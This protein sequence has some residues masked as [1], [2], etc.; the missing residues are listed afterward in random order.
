[1]DKKTFDR[2]FARIEYFYDIHMNSHHVKIANL[3]Y[4]EYAAL[5][6]ELI[7]LGG[8]DI[9]MTHLKLY[10][11][12]EL[13]IR[14]LIFATAIDLEWAKSAY[15]ELIEKSPKRG[16]DLRPTVWNNFVDENYLNATK[17]FLSKINLKRNLGYDNLFL[18]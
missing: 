14:V 9:L 12:R 3:A 13:I 11:N 8:K 18:N 2:I 4:E 10:K 7:G 15:I 6:L 1:M 17:E 5:F 16:T